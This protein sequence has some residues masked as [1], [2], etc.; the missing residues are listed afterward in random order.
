MDGWISRRRDRQDGETEEGEGIFVVVSF[1][2]VGSS[3]LPL[4]ERCSMTSVFF[5]FFLCRPGQTATF[6][7]S[8]L[9]HPAMILIIHSDF[10]SS[11][12]LKTLVHM[13][14]ADIE[15]R[16][17]IYR[18][19]KVWDDLRDLLLKDNQ[20]FPGAYDRERDRNRIKMCRSSLWYASLLPVTSQ[21]T[22]PP[23]LFL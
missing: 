12:S 1:V 22:P 7:L 17:V 15:S 21:S 23:H 2:S 4:V 20:V 9:S 19:F 18:S 5:F 10:F 14:Y 3:L 8:L 11:A 13:F 16:V 6:F